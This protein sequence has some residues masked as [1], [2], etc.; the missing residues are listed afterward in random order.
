MTPS[1]ALRHAQRPQSQ[2][3]ENLME[4]AGAAAAV[5]C[6]SGGERNQP[7]PQRVAGQRNPALELR[8]LLRSS[9]SA[10]P[11][12]A[13]ASSAAADA[14]VSLGAA[15]PGPPPAQQE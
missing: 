6:A 8:P 10:R 12:L 14:C 7:A 4:R 1:L 3:L 9:P 2:Q 5:K 15:S 11:Q 13:P